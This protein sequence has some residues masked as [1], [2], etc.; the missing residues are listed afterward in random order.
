MSDTPTSAPPE[1]P[2]LFVRLRAS[3]S[4][5]RAQTIFGLVAALLSIGG[6]MYGYLRVT[7]PPDVGEL[8]T[9]VR[10]RADKP[11]GEATVEVLTPKD[12][13]VTTLVAAEPGARTSL[14]EGTYRLRVSHPKYGAE[15]RTVQVIAGQTSEIRVRL[16]PRAATAPGGSPVGD[17]SRAVNEGVESLRKIFR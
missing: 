4:L 12:A 1:K 10:D 9:I 11:L 5:S 17:A 3:L 7:R 16:S 2:G 6:S 8:I 14:K 13:L 15:T